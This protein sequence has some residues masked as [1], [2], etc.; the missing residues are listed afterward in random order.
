VAFGWRVAAAS[1][2]SKRASRRL[3]KGVGCRPA[4]CYP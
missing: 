3:M 1:E 4:D 2:V